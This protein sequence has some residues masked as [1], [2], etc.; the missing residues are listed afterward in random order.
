M[1]QHFITEVLFKEQT[2]CVPGVGTFTIQHIPAHFNVVEQQLVPPRQQILFEEKWDDDSACAQWVSHKENLV[3]SVARLKMDKYVLQFK[4]DLAAGQPIA[5][6]SVGTLHKDPFG[7]LVFTPQELPDTWE[8]LVLQPVLRHDSAPKVTVGNTEMVNQQVVNHMSA[9]SDE[10]SGFKWWWVV[11]PL[12][13]VGLG[14]LGWYL[15]Q[16]QSQPGDSTAITPETTV[17]FAPAAIADSSTDGVQLPSDTSELPLPEETVM[18]PVANGDSVQYYAVYIIA[19]AAKADKN[20]KQQTTW[21]QGRAVMY[22]KDDSL[23]FR[24][25]IPVRALPKDTAAV[26]DSMRNALGMVIRCMDTK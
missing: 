6:P 23:T 26:K 16:Q 10:G 8:P 7:Q 5:I 18:Q 9:V 24:I 12:L 20:F 14:G 13:L 1:L 15:W 21:Q 4:D 22:T 17:R 19:N 11:F 2:C 3:E 25:A